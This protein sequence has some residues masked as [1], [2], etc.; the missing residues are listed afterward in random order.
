MS[1]YLDFLK[2]STD[3]FNDWPARA[4]FIIKKRLQFSG[5]KNVWNLKNF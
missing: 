4:R 1:V 2:N 3:F 5:L